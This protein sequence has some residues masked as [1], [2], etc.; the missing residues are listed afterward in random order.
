MLTLTTQPVV[1]TRGIVMYVD[2]CLGGDS[3]DSMEGKIFK[4]V[5]RASA[6]CELGFASSQADAVFRKL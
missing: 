2:G 1:G 5:S 6:G 3:K 4:P